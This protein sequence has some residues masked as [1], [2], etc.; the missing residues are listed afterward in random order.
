MFE[1]YRKRVNFEEVFAATLSNLYTELKLAWVRSCV[2]IGPAGGQNEIQF[3]KRCAAN[4][5][6]FLAVEP[7]HDAVEHLR[8]SL[9][10]TLPGVESQVFETRI[11]SWEGLSDP[12]DLVLMF[13]VLY[14]VRADERQELFKK[15]HDHWLT[16]AGYVAVVSPSRTKSPG[17]THTIFERLDKPSPPWE[18]V[19]SDLQKAGFT[20]VYA[21]EMHLQRDFSNLDDYVL[22]FYRKNGGLAVTPD[23]VRDVIQE[24]FPQGHA[25]EFNMIAIFKRQ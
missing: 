5:S 23:Y 18:D 13:H 22:D 21:Y 15:I 25:T 10:V 14:F 12:V 17:N 2:A 9:R 3:V 7:D 16:S 11:E 20:K 4:I 19:E 24:L 1:A 8:A 6:K